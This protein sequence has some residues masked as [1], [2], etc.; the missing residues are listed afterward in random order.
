MTG[1]NPADLIWFVQRL[2]IHG[3][4]GPDVRQDEIFNALWKVR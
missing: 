1:Q 3:C 4:L 2:F